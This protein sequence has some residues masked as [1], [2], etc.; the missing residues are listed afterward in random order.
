M[1]LSPLSLWIHPQASVEQ[2]MSKIWLRQ[3]CDNVVEVVSYF[4]SDILRYGYLLEE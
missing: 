1:R 3:G 4:Y 2:N